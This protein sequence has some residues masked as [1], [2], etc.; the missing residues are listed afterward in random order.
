MRMVNTCSIPIKTTLNQEEE[1]DAEVTWEDQQKINSF[2]KL[3]AKY[4]DL[5]ETYN[6]KKQEKEFLDDLTSELELADKVEL[7]KYKIGESFINIPAE[8]AIERIEKDKEILIQDLEQLKHNMDDMTDQMRQLK[9]HL[10][11]KFGKAIN[12]EKD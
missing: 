8:Q 10:Y 12:L 2:S 1:V 9:A 3:N 6:A 5:E 4:S 11:G 7:I